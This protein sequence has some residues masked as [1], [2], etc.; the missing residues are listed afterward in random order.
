[1]PRSI[2][3]IYQLKGVRVQNSTLIC[4]WLTQL[5]QVN[6]KHISSITYILCSDKY[7]KGINQ[8]FLNHDYP[9]DI[10]TFNL[11]ADKTNLIAEIYIG[12][13]TIRLNAT[14]YKV[15]VKDEL[16]RVLAHGLLHLIGYDDKTEK[17]I[18]MMRKAEDEWLSKRTWMKI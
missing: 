1:M 8:Q 2:Q 12:Y 18:A 15:T 16:H 13:E 7:I 11:S 17:E 10:I 6:K 9:T 14:K 4:R 5:A 3:F